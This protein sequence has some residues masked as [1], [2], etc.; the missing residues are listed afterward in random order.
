MNGNR[1]R[2]AAVRLALIAVV[3]GGLSA[4]ARAGAQVIEQELASPKTET[5]QAG[6]GVRSTFIRSAGLDPFSSTDLMSQVSLAVEHVVARSDAFAFAAGVSGDFGGS[7]SV[8]RGSPTDLKLWRFTAVAEGRYELWQ[9][10]YG[11]VRF[12]PGMLRASAE[13]D[14]ASS[15]NGQRLQDSFDVLAIDTSAGAALRLSG[16]ANPVAAW[17]TAEAGYGWAG[18]HHLLLTP[19]AAS[20]DQTKLAPLD[21]GTIDPRGAFLRFAVAITY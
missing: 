9:R 18:S 7:D 19:A 14:D 10:T 5:W 11:F 8:A 4:P 17:V 1:N 20:R 15:P 13:V 3:A 21:L 2:S 16:P 6:I 12:A